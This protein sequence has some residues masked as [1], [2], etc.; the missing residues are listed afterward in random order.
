MMMMDDWMDR[1][2]DEQMTDDEGM[3]EWMIGN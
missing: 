1:G 3:D 2:M